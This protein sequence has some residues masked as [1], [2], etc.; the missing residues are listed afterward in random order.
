MSVLN[1]TD[2][3]WRGG[4]VVGN[5]NHGSENL[6]NFVTRKGLELHGNKLFLCMKYRYRMIHTEH[7]A[8]F[9]L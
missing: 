2:M 9:C 8:H 6:L 4:D 3:I 7:P 5:G 1:L